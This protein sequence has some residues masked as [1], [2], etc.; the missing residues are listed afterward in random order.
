M[1]LQQ[2]YEQDYEQFNTNRNTILPHKKKNGHSTFTKFNIQVL[3]KIPPIFAPT[4]D[5]TSSLTTH[6]S[7]SLL[8][9]L[10]SPLFTHLFLS[11]ISAFY[12]GG[13]FGGLWDD[14]LRS[15][16]DTFK[17]EAKKEPKAQ[18]SQRPRS[19]RLF[20]HERKQQLKLQR[21]MV[22]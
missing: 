17:P 22:K 3:Q 7:S 20:R 18:R 9:P 2:G 6:L 16:V 5:P 21:G 14:W 19:Q 4:I 13:G 8:Q 11:T 10:L 1:E 15:A 12:F